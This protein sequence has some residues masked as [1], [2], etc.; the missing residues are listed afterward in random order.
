MLT[1]DSFLC[2]V[3]HCTMFMRCLAFALLTRCRAA[4]PTLLSTCF[5]KPTYK[6][7]RCHSKASTGAI[8]L[9]ILL[10][11]CTA[12]TTHML[13]SRGKRILDDFHILLDMT[14]RKRAM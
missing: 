13:P 4:A 2:A 6:W 10:T 3:Q 8:Q 12:P 5:S 1:A 7:A 9:Q 11:N 14:D